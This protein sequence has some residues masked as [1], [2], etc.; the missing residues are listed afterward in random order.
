METMMD[1]QTQLIAVGV[2]MLAGFL[3]KKAPFIP[4]WLIPA[5]N[6]ILG[7]VAGHFVPGLG[8]AGGVIAGS[9]AVGAHQVKVQAAGQLKNPGS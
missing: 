3:Q 5:I 1:P 6:P 8:V 9:A 7:A 2:G 4:N